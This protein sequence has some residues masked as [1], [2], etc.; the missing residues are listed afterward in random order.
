MQ[1]CAEVIQARH[2]AIVIA[3]AGGE[4][5]LIEQRIERNVRFL[6]QR[7]DIPEMLAISDLLVMPS[8]SE[9]LRLT[10][11]EAIAAGRPVV[12]FD[13]GGFREI[14][15][16]GQ[17]GRVIRPGD[18][19]AFT[20]AILSLLDS[21]DVLAAYGARAFAAAERFGVEYHVKGLLQCYHDLQQPDPRAVLASAS[22]VR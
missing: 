4:V 21:P 17:S 2:P 20:Q 1:A 13:V 5:V 10:A 15:D 9:G 14:V 6:G 3:Q 22:S 16:D 18:N 7:S 11:I 19:E 12:G 8:E